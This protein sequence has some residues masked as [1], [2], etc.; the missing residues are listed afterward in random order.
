MNK[1]LLLTILRTTT[2]AV[3]DVIPLLSVKTRRDLAEPTE[4]KTY[5]FFLSA[6]TG[7]VEGVYQGFIGG[8]FI[9][10]LA[11]LISGQLT[12]AYQ[13][14]WAD[15]GNFSEL[16]DY[17]QNDLEAMI[18]N[19]YTFVDQFYR[20]IVDARVD[21]TSIAP[22]L[23]RATLWAQRWTEAYNNAAAKIVEVNGG[24]LLWK[25]GDTEQHCTVCAG[26][27]GIVARAKEWS[28]LGVRPQNAPNNKLTCGG[29]KCDCSLSPTDKRRSP[30]AYGRIEE[31]LLAG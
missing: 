17:L 2:R 23:N 27:D 19:Q 11:N 5:E 18:L 25:L 15:D 1:S 30:G 6:I 13:R 24:N 10:T 3:P 7:L 28:D 14:A 4:Y 31:I 8:V 26:L 29:W 20:D 22:L 12:D 21:Q 9:D 16:P